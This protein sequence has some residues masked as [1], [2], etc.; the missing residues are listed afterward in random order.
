MNDFLETIFTQ[1]ISC[2]WI[3]DP[4]LSNICGINRQSD[5]PW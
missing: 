4:L 3:I 2:A 5:L 1:Q